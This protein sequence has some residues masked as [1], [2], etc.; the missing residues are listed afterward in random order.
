MDFAFKSFY[1][2]HFEDKDIKRTKA[3]IELDIK[4]SFFFLK[5]SKWRFQDLRLIDLSEK[6]IKNWPIIPTFFLFL[7]VFGILVTLLRHG[8]NFQ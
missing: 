5:I 7:C 1:I 6:S 3:D 2:L 8:E 4:K